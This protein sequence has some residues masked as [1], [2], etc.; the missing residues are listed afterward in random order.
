MSEHET[1]EQAP[2][3]KWYQ[4]IGP[5]IITACVV[6]G[7]GSILT[8]NKIGAGNEFSM[9]WIVVVACIF[10]MFFM[11]MGARIGVVANSSPA[12]LIRQHLGGTLGKALAILVGLCVFCISTAFQFG[13]NLGVQSAFNVY[14]DKSIT[15]YL[16]IGFNALSIS[17][18]FAFKD[19]YKALE[20]VMMVFVGLMLLCF[21]IN[22]VAAKPNIG[23]LAKGFL[24]VDAEISLDTLG[25]IGTTFVVAAAYFQCYLARQKGWSIKELKNGIV[26]ARVGS[27]IMATLT[28]M[29]MAT[30][31]TVLV[32]QTLNSVEDV[33]AGL[34]PAFG[35]TG[36]MLFCIGL[37]S[38]AYS[39]FLV[40]SMI[41][42]FI[43]SDGLQLGA[44]AGEKGPKIITTLVLL[45]GMVVALAAVLMDFETVP[46]VVFA[47]AVTVI[48]NPLLAAVLLWMTNSKKIMGDRT[49]GPITNIVGF[50][51]ISILL[52]MAYRTAFIVI[53][54][55]L[56]PPQVTAVVEQVEPIPLSPNQ[57]PS[58]KTTKE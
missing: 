16:V 42:G 49:N 40:N 21:A 43:L 10:M 22:L 38:A 34:E 25:L 29:L 56:K 55:K 4:A 18:L 31:G 2:S 14:L 50:L 33:A 11:S 20:K 41:A 6:I 8:S 58:L 46:V 5:G 7:P 52:V 47:Q 19:F 45:T 32:G 51:G 54:S 57:T 15:I 3:R 37:F 23:S 44:T 12:D 39:S 17:F 53:P 1:T 30:A 27:V 35:E 13:N 28:I 36:K 9:I 24:P 48:G 26:D